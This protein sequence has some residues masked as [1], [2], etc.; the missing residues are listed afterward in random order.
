MTVNIHF[1]NSTDNLEQSILLL[2]THKKNTNKI[3]LIRLEN[4]KKTKPPIRKFKVKAENSAQI[5]QDPVHVFNPKHKEPTRS[6]ASTCKS[7]GL[8]QAFVCDSPM[9]LNV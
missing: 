6:Y 9:N 3:S 5:P 7:V 4:K 8:R 2:K 1:D